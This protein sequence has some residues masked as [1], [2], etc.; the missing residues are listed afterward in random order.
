MSRRSDEPSAV[1][2]NH[3]ATVPRRDP[4][5]SGTALHILPVVGNSGIED[6]ELTYS[7]TGVRQQKRA[8]LQHRQHKWC[9]RPTLMVL[10]RGLGAQMIRL[11]LDDLQH[12]TEIT[13]AEFSRRPWRT[14]LAERAANLLTRIL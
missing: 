6:C 12:A 3:P 1:A 13:R 9:P 8:V 11:F 7:V 14:R 10:D 5:L 2:R 4:R